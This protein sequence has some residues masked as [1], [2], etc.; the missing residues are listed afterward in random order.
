MKLTIFALAWALVLA[1]FLFG[2]RRESAPE[3]PLFSRIVDLTHSIS[4]NSPAFDESERFRVRTIADYERDGYFAREITLPEHFAT[5][6]DA[7]AHF[8]RGTWTIDEIP[9]ERLVRP[10][11]VL[12]VSAQVQLN[13]DYLLGVDDIAAWENQNGHIPLGAVVMARTGWDQR[14]HSPAAF[15]NA[16]TR[17][18]LHFPGYSLDAAKF[19]VQ[20]R[21]AV[22]LGIDTL[23]VDSGSAHDF[24]V[25]HF[26]SAEGVYHLEAVAN[27]SA[28]PAKGALV[29]VAPAKLKGGSGGP[30]RIL[31]LVR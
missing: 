9:P 26:T 6:V 19:L 31:A 22:A 11:V 16:D 29:V 28:V 20:G 4:E 25:H 27:L 21:S 13:P 23:S 1:I 17:G 8:M 24:P 14:W 12:D 15:R 2:H 18:V 3:S 30:A 5:H 10:L 7:P